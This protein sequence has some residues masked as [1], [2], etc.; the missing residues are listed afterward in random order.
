MDGVLHHSAY[1]RSFRL[2]LSL[3]CTVLNPAS[4]E[5]VINEIHYNP[6]V[7]TEPVEFIELL[8]AGSN[9]VDLAGWYFSDGVKFA[10]PPGTMLAPGVYQV[11]SENPVAL[12]G[13]FGDNVMYTR[14]GTI[15]HEA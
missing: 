6:D 5:I 11:I 7:K 10:F 9:T 12:Q 15:N 4:A 14:M 1:H 8:N 3:T 13:I 2:V